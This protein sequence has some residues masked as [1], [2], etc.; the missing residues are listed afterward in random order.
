MTLSPKA[1]YDGY[2]SSIS[3]LFNEAVFLIVKTNIR[4]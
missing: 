2:D 1:D 4:I 3:R